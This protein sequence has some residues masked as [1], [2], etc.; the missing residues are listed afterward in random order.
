LRATDGTLE[1]TFSS[2]PAPYAVVFGNAEI[3]ITGAPDTYNLRGSDGLLLGRFS[4]PATNTTGV[5]FDGEN[6]WV[7][8]YNIN[9]VGKLDGKCDSEQCSWR[10]HYE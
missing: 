8:E 1:G 2:S 4:P 3:W 9:S 10:N 7:A 6:V 5:A